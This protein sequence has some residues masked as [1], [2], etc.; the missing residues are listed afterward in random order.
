MPLEIRGAHFLIR[1]AQLVR[2]TRLELALEEAMLLWARRPG[3]IDRFLHGRQP[4]GQQQSRRSRCGQCH[5]VSQRTRL[6]TDLLNMVHFYHE[7]WQ[8]NT[9]I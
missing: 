7:H 3:D 9:T 8:L 5:V 1:S 4:V 6:T 2:E